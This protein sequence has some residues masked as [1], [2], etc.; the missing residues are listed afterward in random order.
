M[1][2]F[3]ILQ[4]LARAGLCLAYV[5][6]GVSKLFDFQGAIAEQAHFGMSPPAL[7]AAATIATQLGGSALLL[8]WRG[9]LAALGALALAGFTLLA[10]FIGHPFWNESGMERFADLNSFL[11]HFGLI[12]GFVLV[13]LWELR[14]AAF[15]TVST[16]TPGANA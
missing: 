13:A 16:S 8:L 11:E 15:R 14:G 2:P 12:G 10:T 6:S 4:W 3:N 7:F 9:P 5:Y 1:N